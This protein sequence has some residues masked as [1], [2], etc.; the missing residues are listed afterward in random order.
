MNK[1]FTVLLKSTSLKIISEELDLV[2]E[3]K[4]LQTPVN[5]GKGGGRIAETS[6]NHFTLACLL[7]TYLNGVQHGKK[8]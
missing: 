7:I 1:C 3:L 4:T 8:K 6:S 5:Q 2:F